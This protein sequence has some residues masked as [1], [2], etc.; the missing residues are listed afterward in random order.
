MVRLLILF[1]LWQGLSPQLVRG[2]T[3]LGKW[4]TYENGKPSSIVK[5]YAGK[6]GKYYGKMVKIFDPELAKHTCE[7]CQDYRKN[8]PTQNLVILRDLEIGPDKKSANK[9]K[10]L[11]PWKGKEYNCKVWLIDDRT[12]KLRAYVGFLYGTRTWY[13]EN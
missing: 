12:L 5:I 6:D 3:I 2:Q 8:Q 13:K 10:V 9:G 4:K 11:D 1:I 7:Q